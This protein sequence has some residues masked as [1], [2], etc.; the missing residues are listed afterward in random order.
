MPCTVAVSVP[1]WKV[2]SFACTVP[3]GATTAVMPVFVARSM[4]L[5]ISSA[6]IREI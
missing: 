5:R 2:G 4:G 3:S 6:R 1:T